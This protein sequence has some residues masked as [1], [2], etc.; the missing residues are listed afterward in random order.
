MNLNYESSTF[1]IEQILVHMRL[2]TL[3]CVNLVVTREQYNVSP[4][5]TPQKRQLRSHHFS[6]LVWGLELIFSIM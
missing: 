3:I 2:C 4:H 6:T 5:L 1:K